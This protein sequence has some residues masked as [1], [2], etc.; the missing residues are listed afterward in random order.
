MARTYQFKYWFKGLDC[1][2]IL[3]RFRYA[4]SWEQGAAGWDTIKEFMDD[5][6][7]QKKKKYE[8][9]QKKKEKQE[10]KEGWWEAVGDEHS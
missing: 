5:L 4:E 3:G 9:K 1:F 2:G 10:K 6:E 8:E 7:E